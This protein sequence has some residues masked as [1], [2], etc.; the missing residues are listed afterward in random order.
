MDKKIHSFNYKSTY[1]VFSKKFGLCFRLR[2]S[3]DEKVNCRDTSCSCLKQDL[4]QM[5][6]KMV[7]RRRK[8]IPKVGQSIV[9]W[10]YQLQPFLQHWMKMSG[11]SVQRFS[12]EQS[13]VHFALR[14]KPRKVFMRACKNSFCSLRS[15]GKNY[16]PCYCDYN[17]LTRMF[18]SVTI[19]TASQLA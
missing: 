19:C 16:R 17:L 2:C 3:D 7:Q 6:F 1:L 4:C 8:L 15:K 11:G 10:K 9:V 14:S 12:K 18:L 5:I 13:E